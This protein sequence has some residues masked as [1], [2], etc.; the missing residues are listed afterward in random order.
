[1]W[2]LGIDPINVELINVVNLMP[3]QHPGRMGPTTEAASTTSP[4]LIAPPGLKGL[5]VADTRVGSVQGDEGYFHYREFDAVEIASSQSFETTAALLLDGELPDAPEH[6][7]IRTE[8]ARARHLEPS[9]NRLLEPISTTAPDPIVGL[10]SLLPLVVDPT[11]TLDLDHAERRARAIAAIGAVPT[12]VAGLHCARAG[13]GVIPSDPS[14]PHATDYVRMVTGQ[15]PAP[16]VARAV[17]TYLLLTADHG[18]N[19]STFAARLVTSTGAGVGGAL[20]SALA[21]LSGPLHGGA[22]SRVLDMLDEIGDPANTEAWAQRQLETG[23]KLMGF[24]HAVYRADDPRSDLL[25]TVAFGLGDEL[26]ERAAEIESRMLRVLRS[27]KPEASI[28]TNVEFYAAVVL[29]LAGIPQEMF[30]P[31]F[32]TSRVVGWS[33]HLLEQASDNRLMRPKARYVGAPLRRGWSGPAER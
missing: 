20:T 4:T 15:V 23:R 14:L 17:E 22:P 25:R 18:F 13:R 3:W 21:A 29:H 30:T 12:I 24:G 7:A 8:L 11:P 33:A 9:I 16:D 19:A 28:V 26:V 10:L 32:A 2:G 5:V 27:W 1:M 31:T 6:L